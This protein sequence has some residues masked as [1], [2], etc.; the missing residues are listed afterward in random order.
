MPVWND[1]MAG[2]QAASGQVSVNSAF[3]WNLLLCNEYQFCSSNVWVL[4]HNSVH[5]LDMSTIIVL[6][7]WG[8]SSNAISLTQTTSP[9]QLYTY[10]V[11]CWEVTSP[12]DL[13]TR[14]CQYT[15][16]SLDRLHWNHTGWC[17]HPVVSQWQ[18]SVDLHN[19]NTLEDH[20][21]HKYTGM[22]LEPHWLMLAPSGE[23]VAIQWKH[24]GYQQS[25]H[26]WHSSVHW[27]L[28]PRH[29]G[30]PLNYYWI[31]KGSG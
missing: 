8:W 18:S 16:I 30:L 29:T 2:H 5:D 24:T 9:C 6:Y 19:W 21:S 10:E 25:L 1:K 12:N 14:S 31:T 26:L 4:Q 27:G 28:N 17:Y 15:G 13:Q 23:P 7:I 22:P 3:T 20:W 11:A